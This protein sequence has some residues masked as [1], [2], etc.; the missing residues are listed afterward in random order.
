[1][2]G[3]NISRQRRRT[4]AQAAGD[5]TGQSTGD[6]QIVLVLS[7]AVL[8]LGLLAALARNTK[9]EDE[10]E[11]EHEDDWNKTNLPPID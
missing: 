9:S 7:G 3:W 1:M 6:I 11:D 5:V 10:F 4:K 8:V 2:K